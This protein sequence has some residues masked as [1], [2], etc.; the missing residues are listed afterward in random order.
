MHALCTDCA[1]SKLL[2]DLVSEAKVN[3]TCSV[4]GA[5]YASVIPTD[6]ILFIRAIKALIRYH[7]SEWEYHSKLGGESF[8]AL[9]STEN[10]IIRVNPN[11]DGIE[12]EEFLLSFLEKLDSDDQVSVIT[13][14]GRDIYDNKP[15]TAIS[16]GEAAAITLIRRS[17]TERN[18]FVVE[19]EHAKDF[20]ELPKYITRTFPAGGGWYRA[21]VGAT[22]R[23]INY[24]H[25]PDETQYYFEPHVGAA[26]AAPPIALAS[27]GRLNRPGV[28]FLYLAT[29][30]D[31]AIAE[32]RPHPG[33]LVTVAEFAITKEQKVADLTQH[34]LLKFFNSDRDLALLEIVIA[35]E[36][37]LATAAPPSNRQLYSLTQFLAD[38][39]RTMN[40]DGIA[41]RSTV[42]VGANIVLF[43]PTAA[44]WLEG[45]SRVVEINRVSYQHSP[46]AL[47]D[48][49]SKYDRV[50]GENGK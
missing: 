35:V 12:Y 44:V 22:R 2:K 31:T 7:Y 11:L 19:S 20:H 42:G 34:D 6:N 26:I 46:K 8:E 13:A 29:N 24:S 5:K 1:N 27:S 41:F 4:C 32:V 39:F 43:E 3:G 21:R 16:R 18:Y 23:A 47:F 36:N 45:S 38:I 15:F 30:A 49:A 28:S 40:F 17:L 9:L 48:A 10:P 37:A 50:F 25:P 14:Y 33:E